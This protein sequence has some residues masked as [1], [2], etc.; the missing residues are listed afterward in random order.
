MLLIVSLLSALCL[1][2]SIIIIIRQQIAI[3]SQLN[4]SVKLEQQ[5]QRQHH[6]WQ[7]QF[8]QHQIQ[9]LKTLQESLQNS[10]HLLQQQ[11]TTS[12]TAN[13]QTLDK[14]MQYLTQETQQHLHKISTNVEQRLSEGFAKTTETFTNILQRLALIDAAQ[15]KITELSINVVNLQEI[16]TD[17]RSRGA[18][19]EV[20]LNSLLR[21][22]I[23]ETEFSLQ[24][25]LS[26]G[27]RVDCLLR[28]PE[29]SGNI[30][31]DSK[32]PLEN[33]RKTVE[34]NQSETELKVAQQCFRQDVRRHIQDIAEKYIIPGETSDGAIMFIPAEAIFAEIHSH[35]PELIDYAQQM[36]VWVASPTTMMAIL[37]TARAVIKDAATR[38]QVHIIQSHLR[39]LSIDFQRFYKRMDNLARHIGQAH[40]DV[41]DIHTSAHKITQRF[42]KIEQVDLPELEDETIA[43]S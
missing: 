38:K 19:G 24:A 26:N 35:Y 33:Y 7:H 15:K 29:P 32:F 41:K 28:L 10:I 5:L 43:D 34:I 1:L 13:S 27:K 2:F 30:A 22:M 4:S 40:D 18:F 8:D 12:L 36:H 31:I 21:N 3:H 23:A 42:D 9:Q 25:T 11:I 17:K 16:L 39:S 6:E 14:R 20:Q 37:T